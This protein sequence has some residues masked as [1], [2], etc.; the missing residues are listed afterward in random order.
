MTPTPDLDRAASL[1]A[2]QANRISH[3]GLDL[4]ERAKVFEPTT[5]VVIAEVLD[6]DVW[7]VRPVT[8]VADCAEVIA[9]WLAPGTITRYPTGPQ[10]GVH[11]VD[12]WLA[13]DWELADRPWVGE[14]TLRITR[15]GDPSD[16]WISPP[17][18][19]AGWQ[20]W[21][22][23][24]QEPLRRVESGFV[25]MDK[26]LD[27]VVARDLSSWEW[28]DEEEFA[29]AQAAGLF[30]EAEA[31]AIRSAAEAIAAAVDAGDPPW[32]MTWANWHWHDDAIG[33]Q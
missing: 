14:G 33:S 9:L 19:G 30:D 12:H 31:A 27:L 28:K 29:Y 10:H 26:I 25:T 22:V 18:P 5:R 15:P 6:G 13:H 1:V 11:T 16:V 7:T 8:V 20:G 23:N 2:R 32:D 4:S 17:S 24:M 21:Y 3:Q